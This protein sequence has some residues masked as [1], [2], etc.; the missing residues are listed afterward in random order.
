MLAMKAAF[1][2]DEINKKVLL[3]LTRGFN[4]DLGEINKR[5]LSLIKQL[6]KLKIKLS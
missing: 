4:I 1:I 6:L 3:Y 2:L 5:L